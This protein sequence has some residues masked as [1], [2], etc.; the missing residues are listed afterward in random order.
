MDMFW[1][2]CYDFRWYAEQKNSPAK[3]PVLVFVILAAVLTASRIA[4]LGPLGGRLLTQGVEFLRKEVPPFKIVDGQVLMDA[5]QPWTREFDGGVGV[6]IDTTGK[7]TGLE[8]YIAGALLMKKDL[9]L[10]Q[11]AGSSQNFELAKIKS[12]DS[13]GPEVQAWAEKARGLL[14]PFLTGLMLAVSFAGLGARWLLTA[15]AAY[16]LAQGLGAGLSWSQANR[17]AAFA[18]VPASYVTLLGVLTP[19]RVIML[20]TLV[21]LFFLAVAVWVSRAPAGAPDAGRFGPGNPGNPG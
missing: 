15:G 7:T 11:G 18:L 13:Q 12:F 5:P 2:S 8:K 9:L 17:M 16:L 21:G 4:V 14:Y 19:L 20:P 3:R 1:K 10:K 6:V